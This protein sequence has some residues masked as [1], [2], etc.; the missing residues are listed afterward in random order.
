M[1]MI[2]FFNGHKFAYHQFQASVERY[3]C[4]YPFV[5]SY[6][7]YPLM[8]QHLAPDFFFK[9]DLILLALPHRFSIE[10]VVH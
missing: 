2:P 3:R 5:L 8:R 7:L 9:A 10:S 4:F 6:H 1:Q